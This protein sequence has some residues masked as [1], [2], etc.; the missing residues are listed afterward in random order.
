MRCTAPRVRLAYIFTCCLVARPKISSCL[1]VLKFGSTLSGASQSR[2]KRDDLFY[3]CIDTMSE[4][5]TASELEA[6][7][8]EKIERYTY[9]LLMY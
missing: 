7:L 2:N 6:L 4:I 1:R 8:D 9:V 3:D 5:R